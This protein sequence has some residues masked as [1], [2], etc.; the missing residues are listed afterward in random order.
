[1]FGYIES[2]YTVLN[3]HSHPRRG[4][5]AVEQHYELRK[6]VDAAGVPYIAIFSEAGGNVSCLDLLLRYT[7]ERTAVADWER[8]VGPSTV[9]LDDLQYI[10][11]IED[12]HAGYGRDGGVAMY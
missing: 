2:E 4:A 11:R 10:E 6:P 7:D 3:K 1:M 12:H 5:P 8:L 9:G